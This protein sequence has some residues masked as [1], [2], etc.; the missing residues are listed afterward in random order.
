MIVIEFLMLLMIVM[1][2]V[3]MMKMTVCCTNVLIDVDNP[4]SD[5]HT[6]QGARLGFYSQL[7]FYGA[8]PQY[9]Y[10]VSAR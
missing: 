6:L 3:M 8:R 7:G 1:R 9:K 10:E 2:S 4:E 5:V